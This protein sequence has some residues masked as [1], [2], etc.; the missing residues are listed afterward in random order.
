MLGLKLIPVCKRGPGHNRPWCMSYQNYVI[1][2]WLLFHGT[3]FYNI[4]TLRPRQN[5]GH[6]PD[7]IF[8]WIFLM[9]MYE[10]RVEQH[11]SLLLGDNFSTLVQIMAWHRSGD[12]PMSEPMMDT[13]LTHVCVTRPQ[14]LNILSVKCIYA[15]LINLHIHCFCFVLLGPLLTLQW[16]HNEPDSISNHQLHDSLLNRLFKA[17]IKENI[18]AP[19]HWPSWREFN[20]DRWIPRTKGQ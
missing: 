6:F 19:R 15:V 1:L 17:Q 20:G 10:F 12:I 9:E 5:G 8:K 13:L 2:H 7:D 11:W 14:W 3:Q 4:N 18:K 16:R